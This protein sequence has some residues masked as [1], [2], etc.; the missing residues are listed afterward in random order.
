MYT[1]LKG[2]KVTFD[3]VIKIFLPF[4]LLFTELWKELIENY[5]SYVGL[6]FRN[7]RRII[8][9]LSDDCSRH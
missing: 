5:Q 4:V 2:L 6:N 9:L 8:V 3:I 7:I 1:C